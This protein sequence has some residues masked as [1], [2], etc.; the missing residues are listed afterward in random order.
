MKSKKDLSSNIS[1][2][3]R[4]YLILNNEYQELLEKTPFHSF[5]SI[6]NFSN[7]EIIKQIKARSVIRFE[8]RHHY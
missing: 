6:W 1:R 2:T 4:P 8:I 5:E 7:V 3:E